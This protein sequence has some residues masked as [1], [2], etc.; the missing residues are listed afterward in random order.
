[1][2]AVPVA[3]EPLHVDALRAELMS[4]RNLLGD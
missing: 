3:V 4:I 2:A 1:V